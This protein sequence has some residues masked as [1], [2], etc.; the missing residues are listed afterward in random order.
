MAATE[1]AASPATSAAPAD[2][3]RYEPYDFRGTAKFGREQVRAL[4]V[5]H[6]AFARRVASILGAQ[7]RGLVQV[8]PMGIEQVTFDDYV[9][10][11]PTPAVLGVVDCDPLPAPVVLDLDI[12]LALS[13]VDRML[14][15]DGRPTEVRR[16]TDLETHLLGDVLGGPMQA[17][18]STLEAYTVVQPQLTAL[19][20]NPQLLQIAGP[21][22]LALVLT[23]RVAIVQGAQAEGVL[24]LC[25]PIAALEPIVEQLSRG[26][27]QTEL[28]AGP[29]P[30]APLLAETRV[31]VRVRLGAAQVS[32]AALAALQPG[33]VI[34]LDAEPD[35]PAV[36]SVGDRQVALGH[37]G[38][39]G[40]RLAL[41]VR[42]ARP[43]LVSVAETPAEPRSGGRDE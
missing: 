39:R 3:A 21:A 42:A 11:T 16:P 6:E 8:D 37:I 2:A 23:F 19:E 4:Q 38:R 10:S 24:T 33:D 28:T 26:S 36:A 9:R 31:D 15:G 18:A 7:L 25:Y 41:L 1:L 17:L 34:R 35:E 32:A 29:S 12:S 5:A 13:V 30:L 40:R 14:G 27:G 22:D 43:D 20:H